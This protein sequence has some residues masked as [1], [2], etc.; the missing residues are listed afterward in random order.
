M[1]VLSSYEIPDS[2]ASFSAN[3]S[4]TCHCSLLLG[5]ICRFPRGNARLVFLRLPISD[6]T[7]SRARRLSEQLPPTE[8]SIPTLA[9][10]RRALQAAMLNAS[11]GHHAIRDGYA[12]SGHDPA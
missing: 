10:R 8:E 7:T 12:R 9:G 3:T 11:C 5:R 2:L 4:G 1:P 6:D